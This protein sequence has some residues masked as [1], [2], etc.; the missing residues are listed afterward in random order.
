[1]SIT[2]IAS[3]LLVHVIHVADGDTF[4]AIDSDD[5][6]LIV[7]LADIDAPENMQ[8]GGT[9]SKISL[10]HL[11][12]E[13]TVEL[14]CNNVDRYQRKVCNVYIESV[15]VNEKMVRI[16]AAWVS[17]KFYKGVEFY[18]LQKKAKYSKIGLWSTP[19]PIPPWLWRRQAN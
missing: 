17:P 5:E 13:K 10:T 14:E 3:L 11:I 18:T 16:G 12:K 8:P 4:T 19:S 9:E 6:T 15:F 7:R 1:M 2:F